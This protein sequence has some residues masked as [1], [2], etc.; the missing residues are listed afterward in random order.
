MEFRKITNIPKTD[1]KINHQ[2]EILLFGSCF[3]E[4]IGNMLL[5]NKFRV[6]VNPFGILYNPASIEQAINILLDEK[7]FSESDIF[8]SHGIFHTFFHHSRFSGTNKEIF[9]DEI[10]SQRKQASSDIKVADILLITFGTSY[11]FKYKETG[12]VVANCHKLPASAFEHVRLDINETVCLWNKLILKIRKINPSVKLLF[13]VSPVRHLKN[14][15]HNNQLSKA[16]LL[17]IIENLINEHESIYYFPSYEIMLDELRDYRFYAEDMIHPNN[18]SINY[19]WEKFSKTY[20]SEETLIINTQWKKI[21][22][23]ISHRPFNEH[24]DEYKQFLRQTL[25]KINDLRNKYPYFE[26]SK[27]MNFLSNKLAHS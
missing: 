15:A 10:N 26:C 11:I 27:E 5:E 14:G 3:A 2:S 22:K 9:I 17:L 7:D 19:I 8:E 23:A 25:L 16:I 18:I 21:L 6:N 13:T 20:F 12:A 1:L 24:T 4:H